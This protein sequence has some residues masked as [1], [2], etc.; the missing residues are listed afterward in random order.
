MST[1]DAHSNDAASIARV[2]TTFETVANPVSNVDLG[3][4]FYGRSRWRPD[5]DY[6][7]GSDFRIIQFTPPDSGCSDDRFGCS[8]AFGKVES[9]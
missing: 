2:D 8:F 3:K 4:E 1:D 5:A 9:R 6:D 7:K